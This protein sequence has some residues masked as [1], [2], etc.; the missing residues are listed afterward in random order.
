MFAF[1][2]ANVWNWARLIFLKGGFL[3]ING[4]EDY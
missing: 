4:T 3:V 2:E 1:G